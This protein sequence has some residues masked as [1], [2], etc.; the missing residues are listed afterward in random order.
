MIQATRDVLEFHRKH[1][2]TIGMTPAVP[3]AATVALRQRL[4]SE[5][6]T[7]LMDAIN[8]DDLACIAKE[9]VDLL[10]V[11]V[12]TL[13]AYGIDPGLVWDAVHASNMT[14]GDGKRGDAKVLKG[15]NYAPPDIA[16]ILARQG[17]LEA[18][19]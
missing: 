8:H 7:E 6:F 12:G 15:P 14:K 16:V 3:D 5:E 18:T 4:I 19:S 17:P 13:I 11:T 9:A 10:Y 2:A 1:G